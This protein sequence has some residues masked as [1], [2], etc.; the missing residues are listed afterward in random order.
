MPWWWHSV[1]T[2]GNACLG[3][4]YPIA[5]SCRAV[6]DGDEEAYHQWMTYW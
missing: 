2:G 5:E 4:V 1:L 6:L 3:R